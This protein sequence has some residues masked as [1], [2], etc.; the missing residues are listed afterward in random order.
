MFPGKFLFMWPFR[1]EENSAVEDRWGTVEEER[2]RIK[3]VESAGSRGQAQD[4]E[5]Q[6]RGFS[7][8]TNDRFDSNR[9]RNFAGGET[10]K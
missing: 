8:T 1:V 2:E 5:K 7:V 6:T 4:R 3:G 10:K 9:Y